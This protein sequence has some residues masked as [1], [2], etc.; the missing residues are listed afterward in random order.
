MPTKSKDASKTF[1]R[2]D[3]HVR[4]SA[5][6]TELAHWDGVRQRSAMTRAEHKLLEEQVLDRVKVL[7][8]QKF[9]RKV[10]A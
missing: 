9:G 10:H 6:I 3:R 2:I 4:T 5:T 1:E 7:M 8:E